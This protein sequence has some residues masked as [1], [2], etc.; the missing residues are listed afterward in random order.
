[1]RAYLA[2]TAHRPATSI[3]PAVLAAAR[4]VAA[5]SVPAATG[6]LRAAEWIG[7]GNGVALLAWTNEPGLD[8]DSALLAPSGAGVIGRC[9]YL[10]ASGGGCYST[11]HADADGFTAGTS[12]T[13]ICPVYHAEAAGL[14]IAGS[15][16]LLVHLAARAAAGQTGVDIDV[17]PLQSMIRHGF[18]VS[19]ET[20]FRGVKALP[21]AATLT[22]R[23]GRAVQ[24]TERP[25]PESGRR[26]R[27]ARTARDHLEPL[28]AALREA[29]SPLDA[30]A[31]PAT[32]A[33]SG[34]RDSRLLA[35]A[36]SGAGVPF[37]AYTHGFAGAPDIDLGTQVAHALGVEHTVQPT[38]PS[39][40]RSIKIQ[41][42]LLR[43]H[44]IVRMC[45]GM[46]SAYE[47][48]DRP[49]TYDP[50]PRTSGSG[51]ET[52]RGGFLYDQ[53][54]VDQSSVERRVHTIFY[55]AQR[56]LTPAAEE[57]ARPLYEHWLDR[58]RTDRFR[59]LDE[60]YLRYRTGRWLVGSHTATL[61]NWS[62]Y[63]PFLDENVV[64]EALALSAEW[65]WTE[66]P[67]AMLIERFAPVL[68][69]IP[70]EGR[71]WKFHRRRWLR[72]RSAA[73]PGPAAF[74][75]RKQYDDTLQGVF[76]DVILDA[77]RELFDI[78]EESA[79]K[80]L[81]ARRP[82]AW[83]NQVW[84]LFTVAVLLSGSWREPDPALPAIELPVPS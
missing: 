12:V 67:V 68:S 57:H 72:R 78:A 82:P 56:F 69:D 70:I 30:H 8:D 24:I 1:L 44:H 4:R 61:V 9:G 6:D 47:N 40:E 71:P 58:A 7:A 38:V 59:V 17:M 2:I 5:G 46:N 34:G 3:P 73:Q 31:E 22:A 45:E 23:R 49:G 63:H 15:R 21:N 52:L 20:P 27:S 35:A 60:L 39:R 41:H 50:A 48:V 54:N 55:S 43:A 74:N 36:L 62:Y 53:G 19:D 66:R 29:V 10:T 79:V 32:L 26:P 16:A 76:R 13:R 84:N 80:E 51:G 14:H 11:F 42:P 81:L 75:W 28:A 65:R 77:P 83:P 37:R 33:L 64:R 25:L 18:I